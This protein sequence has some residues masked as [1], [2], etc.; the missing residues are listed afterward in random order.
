MSDEMQRFGAFLNLL[1]VHA[2]VVPAIESDLVEGHGLSLAEYELLIRLV[3]GGPHRMHE[4]A[5]LLMVTKG[6][7]SKLVDRLVRRDLVERSDDPDD[8]R[9]VMASATDAGRE[10]I[11]AAVPTFRAAL[12][13]HLGDHLD[14]GQI[15]ALRDA[16]RSL[17]EGHGAWSEERCEPPMAGAGD[18]RSAR[19]GD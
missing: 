5:D 17:L 13:A 4:L 8:R 7:V 1:Q 12:R 18:R 19:A 15:S 2:V 11:A 16:F 10:A 9:V 6:G 3:G 14:D